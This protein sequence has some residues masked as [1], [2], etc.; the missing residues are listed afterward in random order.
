MLE[1]VKHEEKRPIGQ[2]LMQPGTGVA[3]S[4]PATERLKGGRLHELRGADRGE[5]DKGDTIGKAASNFLGD[6][7]GQSR[8]AGST[9]SGERQQ[10]YVWLLQQRAQGDQCLI[11]SH[12]RR[13]LRREARRREVETSY[14]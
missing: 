8:L 5:R 4:F 6:L 12:Q 14:R 13:T 2:Q 10:A 7:N 11:A 9:W 1:V 3:T